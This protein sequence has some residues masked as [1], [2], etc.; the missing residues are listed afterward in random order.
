MDHNKN[1][2]IINKVKRH[3]LKDVLPLDKPLALFIEPTNICNFKCKPCA[4]GQKKNCEDLKPF[5]HLE[6]DLYARMIDE[7]KNWQGEKLKLLRLTA[8]GEPFMNPRM[9]EMI[10][11]AKEADVAERVDLFSNGSL[12]TE[13]ISRKL[14]DSE[15]DFIRFSIYAVM[16]DHHQEVVQNSFSVQKIRENIAALRRIRDEAGKT[17]PFIQVKMFDT[18]SY[19]ND[20]FLAMY[21]DIADEVGFEKVHDATK[22]NDSDLIGSYYKNP[23][24]AERTRKEFENSLNDFQTCP[25]PFMAMVVCANGD[26][27]M[28]THDAPRATKIA[29]VKDQSLQA[30]WYG[31]SLYNFRKMLLTG[32]KEQ[33]RLCKHCEWFRLFPPE[34]NV[35][36][37][38]LEKLP[39]RDEND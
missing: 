11:M 28:C 2:T 26:V 29:S 15:L 5:M 38:P 20:V 17:K 30:I 12:V 9:C 6:F 36:G 27:V 4:H 16:P 24:D 3:I 14:V 33:N 21:K 32:H 10:Q 39:G 25:R 37:F 31:H 8:L 19:E 23:E 22:Y 1:F 13:E 7:L 35:D 18:Y 34:D